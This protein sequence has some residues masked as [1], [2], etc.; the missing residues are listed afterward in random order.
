MTT[1]RDSPAGSP[2]DA[3]VSLASLWFVA[4]L[5]IDGWAH[6]NLDALGREGFFTPYH[7]IFYSGF[8]AVAII[9]LA[10]TYRGRNAGRPRRSA[11]PAG[12]DMTLVGLGVFALGGVLDMLWH[13]AFGIERDVAALFSPTHLVLGCGIALI[14]TGPIRSTLGRAPAR[15]LAAQWPALVSLG[16][17]AT[18]VMFFVLWV[19]STFVSARSDPHVTFPQLGGASLDEVRESWQ[20]RGLAAIV[21]RSLVTMALLLWASRRFA[22]PFGA[23]VLLIGMPTVLISLMLAPSALVFGQALVAS[24][25]AGVAA[26]LALMR[27]AS[28]DAGT[29]RSRTLAFVVPFLFWATFVLVSLAFTRGSWWAIHLLVGAPVFAGLT[30]LLL[31]IVVERPASVRA[32][33]PDVRSAPLADERESGRP[34]PAKATRRARGRTKRRPTR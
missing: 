1:A 28:F 15:S 8:V 9:V 3:S 17:F 22:L 7:A 27:G 14:L 4:G 2:F 16:L 10:A 19:F 23:C 6:T 20:I 5:L 32:V 34:H 26:D 13:L 31:A 25:I 18:L 11:V 24:T 30:G 33:T 29:W 12:Y 21:I